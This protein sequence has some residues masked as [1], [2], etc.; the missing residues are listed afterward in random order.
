MYLKT[1]AP[2]ARMVTRTMMTTTRTVITAT[3]GVSDPCVDF[4]TP[5][6]LRDI[7]Q[8][9]LFSVFD[10]KSNF[11]NEIGLSIPEDCYTR[12]EKNSSGGECVRCNHL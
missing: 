4:N 1:T 10:S 8:K 5:K 2:T 11:I 7:S 12:V 3:Y 9:Q 6:N